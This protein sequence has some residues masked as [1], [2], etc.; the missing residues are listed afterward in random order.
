MNNVVSL[1][2]RNMVQVL[3]IP[4]EYLAEVIE[5]AVP[6]LRLGQERQ[7]RNIGMADIIDDLRIGNSILWLVYIDTSLVAAITTS[8]VIHPK[9]RTFKIEFMGG[10]R[11]DEWMEDALRS[12]KSFARAAGC[13][14]VEADGRRGFDRIAGAMD[15]KEI[16]THYEMEL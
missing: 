6:L 15:F 9:R 8:I 3:T 10:S 12:F 13:E 7:A 5:E 14:A 1:P 16:Y 2:L 4:N 11:M